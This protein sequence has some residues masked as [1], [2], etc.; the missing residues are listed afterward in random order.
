MNIG[1]MS[2]EKK[3]FFNCFFSMYMLLNFIKINF[4]VFI[5]ILNH[6]WLRYY[7]NSEER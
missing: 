4:K 2:S 6:K 7:K 3:N 5:F 1:I